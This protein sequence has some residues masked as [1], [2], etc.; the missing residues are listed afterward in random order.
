MILVAALL[1]ALMQVGIEIGPLLAGAGII[2]LAVSFG[3]Q[4][5]DVGS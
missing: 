5:V 4:R 1:M 3:A 2:G